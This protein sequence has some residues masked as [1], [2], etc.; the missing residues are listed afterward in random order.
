MNINKFR[1]LMFM[2]TLL[3]CFLV[4]VFTVPLWIIGE[5][6]NIQEQRKIRTNGDKTTRRS[7]AGASR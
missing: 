2:A 7:I 1:Y 3:S 6:I 5:V 4:T